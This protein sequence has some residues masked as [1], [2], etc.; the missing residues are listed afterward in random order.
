MKKQTIH[1]DTGKQDMII[2]KITMCLYIKPSNNLDFRAYIDE[3]L[4]IYLMKCM[5]NMLLC[6]GE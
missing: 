5:Q 4:I 1:D 2:M 6:E 3:I